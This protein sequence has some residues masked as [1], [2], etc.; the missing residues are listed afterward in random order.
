MRKDSSLKD[1]TIVVINSMT[2]SE[3]FIF[4]AI[5]RFGVNII[6]VDSANEQPRRLFDHFIQADMFNARDVID[7]I[8]VFRDEHPEIKID[9]CLTFWEEDI[10]VCARVCE[11]FHWVGNSYKAAINTRNKFEMRKRFRETGLGS[12]DFCLVKSPRDITKAIAQVGFPAVMKPAWGCDSE[13]VVLVRDESEAVDT[14]EYFKQNCNEE[15][16]SIFRYNNGMFLFEEYVEGVEISLECFSQFGIPH[17]IGMNEKAPMT[18]PYFIECGDVSPPRLPKDTLDE[19]IKLGESALIALGVRN[20]VAHI[21]MK[22]TANGP[23]LIEVASRMG[24]DDIHLYVKQVWGED[25]IKI[26]LQI[27]CDEKVEIRKREPRECIMGR[28]FIPSASG[29]VTK[30]HNSVDQ[31]KDKNI[32]NLVIKKNVGDAVLTPPEGFDTIGWVVT[33]GQTYQEAQAHLDQVM[34]DLEINVTKFTKG[35]QLG[36]SN[37]KDVLSSASF[38]RGQIMRAARLE[39]IRSIDFDA[40]KRLNIGIITNSEL[41]LIDDS[42]RENRIGEEIQQVLRSRNYKVSLFDMNESPLPIRKIE[43]ANL[44][45][46]FNLCEAL[47]NSLHLESHAAALLDV[48]QI[49]YS[50]ASPASLSLCV[51]KILVK[52]LFEYHEIPTPDWDYAYSMDD[53]IRTD[54]RYPLIVKP[55]NTDNSY[56]ITNDSIVTNREELYRQLEKVIIGYKRPALIEEFIDGDEFDACILGNNDQLRVLP[57][58]RSIFRDVPSGCWPIYGWDDRDALDIELEKPAKIP[59]KLRNLICEIALDCFNLFNLQDYGKIEF[60]VDKSGNPYVLEVNPNPPVGREY[61]FPMSAQAD[62]VEYEELV[63]EL[64]M[65]AVQRYKASQSSDL[66]EP[67]TANANGRALG[68]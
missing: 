67:A 66:V 55:A 39:K 33:R 36:R 26:A 27:A 29:I 9:G 63:E 61:F 14:L 58:I 15:F 10:P 42:F 7:K 57:L 62:G 13:F 12:P 25:L 52:K 6:V 24:G 35:F 22:I 40:L 28:Y 20:S 19:A 23:K 51:D 53:E 21:E 60:R 46:V 59:E 3:Q 44:D 68:S 41:P 32:L 43:S 50:G 45:F 17:V 5:R 47:H 65:V 30:V 11:H 56:G 1:K 31:R 37:G 48:L 64:L 34:N 16:T 54:L 38:F 18:P 2:D 8:Q 4:E 49:P